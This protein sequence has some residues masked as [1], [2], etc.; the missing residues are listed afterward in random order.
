LQKNID[1]DCEI[2]K[3]A[4][5]REVTSVVVFLNYRLLKITM[6][7]I[8][9]V[10]VGLC[11]LLFWANSQ[12]L[13][14]SGP[15]KTEYKVM[16]SD[17]GGAG[18]GA[19]Y[20]FLISGTKVTVDLTRYLSPQR[21]ILP[22]GL[23][24]V[25]V[26]LLNEVSAGDGNLAYDVKDNKIKVEP[27]NRINITLVKARKISFGV[28][29]EQGNFDQLKS[30]NYFLTYQGVT[31]IGRIDLAKSK[32]SFRVPISWSEDYRTATATYE[33]NGKVYQI[34]VEGNIYGGDF[35]LQNGTIRRIIVSSD[36]A[37]TLAGI[38]SFFIN[39]LEFKNP[40][41]GQDGMVVLEDRLINF[42]AQEAA[43]FS[44]P[45]EYKVEL[46]KRP[47]E[48]RAERI[49]EYRVFVAKPAKA[50]P[51]TVVRNNAEPVSE[52]LQDDKLSGTRENGVAIM[53]PGPGNSSAPTDAQKKI[54][55]NTTTSS[56]QLEQQLKDVDQFN[57]EI[58]QRLATLRSVVKDDS[59]IDLD[60]KKNLLSKIEELER[61]TLST[62]S[63]Y[64][65]AVTM[66]REIVSQLRGLLAN[67]NPAIQD[68]LAV[69][70]EQIERL[71]IEKMSVI[72]EKNENEANFRRDILITTLI[73]ALFL[74]FG[75]GSYLAAR[76]IHRQKEEIALQNNE[77]KR[78]NQEITRQND[79]LQAQQIEISRKN[80][81]L[82]ELN[83]EKNSLMDIVA[84]DLKAPLSKMVGVTQLLP[85][86][87]DLNDEQR[88][89][90]EIIRKS[91]MEGT[92]FINDLLDINAIEQG[93]VQP[94]NLED[95]GLAVFV[96]EVLRSFQQ[97]ASAKNIRIHFQNKSEHGLAVT[98]QQYF[99]RIVDN[100]VSNA[101]KFSPQDT[102]I[103]VKLAETSDQVI[104]SVKDEGPGISPEDQQKL[105]K[106]FQRLS[107]RP[108]GG[109]SS[110][111]IGLSIVKV[112]VDRLHGEIKAS[113]TLGK[114]AEFTVSLPKNIQVA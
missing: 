93:H 58:K 2:Q 90:V 19:K 46:P 28:T 110:T 11:G 82:L 34:R 100:L 57:R 48:N 3:T 54:I 64:R 98:D 17:D 5:P 13:G 12:A 62:D 61:A 27:G 87:G 33:Q 39:Q 26:Q 38:K 85:V 10:L 47:T 29:P 105:F 108:T 104:L 71:E 15:K 23:V 96:P 84:H 112:L 67:G 75:I 8:N 1:I 74:V 30:G 114:G 107:A 53:G 76:R 22:A 70:A 63:V 89:F 86:V 42:T 81:F 14:Q 20:A 50:S 72:R 16:V 32:V 77:I 52:K 21:V 102:N 97:E 66:A 78:K 106:K 40:G 83:T 9:K 18:I 36:D 49:L 65:E 37:A 103:Y 101:I 25:N 51:T 60:Q 24:E 73:G 111:G 92:R 95:I 69:L 109:E 6:A 68:S 55:E 91:A 99:R 31:R 94:L 56:R 7:S 45:K 44:L 59:K 79:L 80:Q 35:Y 43:S 4:S 88:M 113:S 41:P